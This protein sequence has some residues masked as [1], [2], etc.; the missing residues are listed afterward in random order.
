MN[1]EDFSSNDNSGMIDGKK[2]LIAYAIGHQTASGLKTDE[3]NLLDSINRHLSEHSLHDEVKV[4]EVR[5]VVRS[6]ENL[7]VV[8]DTGV[9]LPYA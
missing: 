7:R 8:Y 9:G 1:G 3:R 2:L 6:L 5:E 4:E